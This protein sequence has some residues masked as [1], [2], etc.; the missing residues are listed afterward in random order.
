MSRALLW[1]V[2]FLF[3]CLHL[4]GIALVF[5]GGYRAGHGQAELSALQAATKAEREHAASL[6]KLEADLAG[7]ELKAARATART[8]SL[9]KVHQSELERY[10]R[11]LRESGAAAVLCLD[12]DGMRLWRGANADAHPDSERDS[13]EPAA[14]PAATPADGRPGAEPVAEPHGDDGAV[15][16]VRGQAPRPGVDAVSAA[17]GS[18]GAVQ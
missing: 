4:A 8:Q 18:D 15:P 5:Q 16:G 14:V 1:A 10:A 3:A 2:P 7:L 9:Q 6:A 11:K 12:A 17:G 13:L